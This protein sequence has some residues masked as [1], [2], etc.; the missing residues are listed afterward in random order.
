MEH[1]LV[2]VALA[3]CLIAVATVICAIKAMALLEEEIVDLMDDVSFV[4]R[5]LR[6]LEMKQ[7]AV[8]YDRRWE[9]QG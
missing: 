1:V 8:I 5:E 6:R 9:A 3:G 2:L 4:E 7:Q